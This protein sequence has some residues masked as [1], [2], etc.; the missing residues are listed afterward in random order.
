M[1]VQVSIHRPH[2]DKE[3]L[4]LDSMYRFSEAARTQPG[5]REVY[6][7]KDHRTGH[8]VGIA[9]WESREAAHAARPAIL[10]A[11]EGDDFEAW[12]AEEPQAY[13]LEAP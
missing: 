10:A 4:L 5:L 7:L 12:E 11:V 1:F 13:H 6:A 2:A 9:I 8:L 3:A